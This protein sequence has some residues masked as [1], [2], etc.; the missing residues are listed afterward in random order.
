MDIISPAVSRF[1]EHVQT[2]RENGALGSAESASDER[3]SFASSCDRFLAHLASP[4][5]CPQ[6]PRRTSQV[7]NRSRE[8]RR[9]Q[10]GRH[11][12]LSGQCGTTMVVR[13]GNVRVLR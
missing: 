10:R 12:Q 7:R 9:C 3:V 1:S 13:Y 5:P 4:L 6:T 8:P 11:S 2:G